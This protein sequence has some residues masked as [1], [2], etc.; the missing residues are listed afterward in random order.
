MQDSPALRVVALTTASP[1]GL[2]ILRALA[3]RGVALSGIVVEA[4]IGFSDCFRTSN[5]LARILEAPVALARALR[6]RLRLRRAIGAQLRRA[7]NVLIVRDRSAPQAM[8]ELSS[9]HP[10]LLVLAGVGLVTP[11]LLAIPRLG[12]LNGHPA[13]LPW[14]RGNGVVLHSILRGV[15]VGAAVHRVDE[16]IDTGPVIRQRLLD[17]GPDDTL[18]TLETRAIHLAHELL[19]DVV[20]DA[21]TRRELPPGE[22]QRDRFPLCRWADRDARIEVARR[23]AGGAAYELFRRWKEC[24]ADNTLDL[25]TDIPSAVLPPIAIPDAKLATQRRQTLIPHRD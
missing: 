23:V 2:N 17:V 19:A 18:E 3:E 20:A 22:P 11:E 12:T 4:R 9:L 16:G 21:T 5:R 13:L 24:C 10:D 25:R 8:Q 6:R 15:A 7:S 14:A 1:L